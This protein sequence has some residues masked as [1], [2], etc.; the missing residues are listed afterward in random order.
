MMLGYQN[1]R[2]AR[3]RSVP[4][5]SRPAERQKAQNEPTEV[6]KLY[7][8]NVL[9]GQNRGSTAQKS[10]LAPP[11]PESPPPKVTFPSACG[12]GAIGCGASR[13]DAVAPALSHFF[14]LAD[15]RSAVKPWRIPSG[16][17][18]S[19][20]R[21]PSA[22]A[23]STTPRIIGSQV[24]RGHP[25]YGLFVT[26]VSNAVIPPMA[27][28]SRSWRWMPRVSVIGGRNQTSTHVAQ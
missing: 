1:H 17:C 19:Q 4:K 8:G 28:T 24:C 26:S 12:A 23:I 13:L 10:E 22:T 20:R 3:K 25:R 9:A 6:R 14:C 16:P 5:P 21:K 7:Q 11:P 15:R 18:A 2:S 27:I